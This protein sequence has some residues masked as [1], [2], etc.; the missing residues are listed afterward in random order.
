MTGIGEALPHPLNT[1]AT[2]E[3]LL[4]TSKAPS[5]SGVWFAVRTRP[6]YEKK[7]ATELREKDV[8]VFLPLLASKR[9][10]SDRQNRA[11]F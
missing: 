6:Y 8:E 9:Q 1:I 11:W 2:T 7:V 5:T 4:P 3:T 10:W